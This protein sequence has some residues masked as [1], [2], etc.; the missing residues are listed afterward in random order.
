[1]L[2]IETLEKNDV[3]KMYE[4]YDLWP[5]LAKTSFMEKYDIIDN[6]DVDH[7]VF[8]GMG[9]SGNIGDVF[10]LINFLKNEKKTSKNK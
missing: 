9:G 8:V 6:F 10:S 1:M 3:K 5:K 2:D 7:L 4:I